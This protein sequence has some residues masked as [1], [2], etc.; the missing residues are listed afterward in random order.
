M[1]ENAPDFKD[2]IAVSMKKDFLQEIYQVVSYDFQDSSEKTISEKKQ[3]SVLID[4][5]EHFKRLILGRDNWLTEELLGSELWSHLTSP[6]KGRTK[7]GRMRQFKQYKKDT[8]GELISV[9]RN[10]Q[11]HF[12]EQP[13]KIRK[14]ILRSNKD[15]SLSSPESLEKFFNFWEEKFPR[16]MENL[17]DVFSCLELPSLKGYYR[18]KEDNDD[19]IGCEPLPEDLESDTDPGYLSNDSK[20]EDIHRSTSATWSSEHAEVSSLMEKFEYAHKALVRDVEHPTDHKKKLTKW[21]EEMI[22]KFV[23]SEKMEER[24]QPT[25]IIPQVFIRRYVLTQWANKLTDECTLSESKNLAVGHGC[26]L[27]FEKNRLML[28]ADSHPLIYCI[29]QDG[30]IIGNCM[31]TVGFKNTVA[32]FPEN[33]QLEVI[34]TTADRQQDSSV[35]IFISKIQ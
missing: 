13:E 20:T 31:I 12:V 17:Y 4:F 35:Q 3:T 16:F 21:Q 18:M 23:S 32:L 24:P 1:E 34:L 7:G 6:A 5:L 2:R 19:H 25:N 26:Y 15:L 22:E 8:I 11:L 33:N 9:I 29:K 10:L 28:L 30:N 14:I 27:S